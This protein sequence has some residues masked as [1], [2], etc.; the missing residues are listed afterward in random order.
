MVELKRWPLALNQPGYTYPAEHLRAQH[1]DETSGGN[2]VGSPTALKVQ[3]QPAPDGTVN[4]VPGG[5][6]IKLTY[7]G[8]EGQSY[9]AWEPSPATLTVPPTGSSPGGRHDLVFLRAYDPQYADYPPG[10]P[11]RELTAEE[12]AEYDFLAFEVL[13]GASATE[14]LDFPHVKLAHI[15]R[16]PNQTIVRPQDIHDLRELAA[17]KTLVVPLVKNI[18]YDT[19]TAGR[20][21]NYN[22]LAEFQVDVPDWATTAVVD[23]TL[24]GCF[25]EHPNGGVTG[26]F[27]FDGL[28][29]FVGGSQGDFQQT[30]WG[31]A[32]SVAY[33]RI[34]F[35]AGGQVRIDPERRGTAQ[36]VRLRVRIPTT[37]PVGSEAG[38][39]P[40]SLAKLNVTF[41]QGVL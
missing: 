9:H 33:E 6:T 26:N 14:N 38:T 27:D 28:G 24:A 30:G 5:A 31:A 15:R 3:A 39:E 21:G 1:H 13:Q 12:A 17:P 2:G 4:I 36:R 25:V 35:H 32:G 16:G 22:T 40:Q 37:A 19:H 10:A 20:T 29:S 34:D 41:Q 18:A 23:G 8:A 7:A 11:Q